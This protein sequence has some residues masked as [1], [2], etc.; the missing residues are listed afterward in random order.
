MG[1][2]FVMRWRGYHS[3][4]DVSEAGFGHTHNFIE[5]F[6]PK[7]GVPM[8]YVIVTGDAAVAELTNAGCTSVPYAELTADDQ[9]ISQ[10]CMDNDKD[11]RCARLFP[12]SPR[13]EYLIKC[14]AIE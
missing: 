2:G 10:Y 3:I 13:L 9:I 8:Q 6:K 12:Y 7:G 4:S 5:N 1:R 11:F 14:G